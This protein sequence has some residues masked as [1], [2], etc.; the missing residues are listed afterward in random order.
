M[1]YMVLA[2][3]ALALAACSASGEKAPTAT[4]QAPQQAVTPV[5]PADTALPAT[6]VPDPTVAP[7]V[8][9][10]TE[11]A[12]IPPTAPAPVTGDVVYPCETGDCDCP[13][14]PSHAEAQRVYN[15]HGGNN[16]SRLDANRDGIACETLP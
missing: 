4:P 7:S 10:A 6:R 15:K 14:F 2:A 12:V 9:Q 16:W 5:G 11:P 3:L 1:R 8:A 13:D